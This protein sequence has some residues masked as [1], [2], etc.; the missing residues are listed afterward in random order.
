[1]NLLSPELKSKFE[2]KISGEILNS[3]I[4]LQ[5]YNFLS[6]LG[7]DKIAEYFKEHQ[8]QEEINHRNKFMEFAT[9]RNCPISILSVNPV[10]ININTLKDVANLY[11]ERELLTTKEIKEMAFLAFESED[12]ITYNF[13]MEMLQIQYLEESE[14]LNL[15]D[16]INNIGDDPNCWQIFN[17]TFTLG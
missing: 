11:V 17:N 6:I 3:N 8:A 4:Y 7:L 15:Q 10:D 12:L 2:Q 9:N 13:L 1:M 14:A 5:I 16:Q